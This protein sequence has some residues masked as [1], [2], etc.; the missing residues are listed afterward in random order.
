MLHLPL[1]EDGSKVI[2]GMKWRSKDFVSISYPSRSITKAD[3]N[4]GTCLS[5]DSNTAYGVSQFSQSTSPPTAKQDTGT[6]EPYY[7][8]M[9][10]KNP[11]EAV[12]EYI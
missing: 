1:L 11:Q 3:Y 8:A 9:E 4:K 10:D 12:Y 2:L 6:Y 7:V 5:T